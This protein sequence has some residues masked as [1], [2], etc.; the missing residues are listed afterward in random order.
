M[1]LP[2]PIEEEKRLEASAEALERIRLL[3]GA[4]LPCVMSAQE[5]MITKTILN[6]KRNKRISRW[7]KMQL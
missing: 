6:L 5:K 4:F 7:T 1:I 3:I 2:E